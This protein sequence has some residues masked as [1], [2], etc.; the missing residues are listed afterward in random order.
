MTQDILGNAPG[1]TPKG[2]PVERGNFILG[3]LRKN[4][5]NYSKRK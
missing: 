3:F 1:K 4:S 5:G 2:K